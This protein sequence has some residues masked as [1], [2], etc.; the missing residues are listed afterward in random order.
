ME[1]HVWGTESIFFFTKMDCLSFGGTELGQ[2]LHVFHPQES[3]QLLCCLYVE[4][5]H[6]SLTVLALRFS[7]TENKL[8]S[9]L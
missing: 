6:P 7:L 4:C 2:T 5:S 8:A 1:I 9:K 3:G